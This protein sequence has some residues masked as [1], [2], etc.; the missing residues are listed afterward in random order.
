M[1]TNPF[2]NDAFNMVSLTQAINIL[3]TLYGRVGQLKIFAD[4]GVRTR[5]IAVEEMNGVLTLLPTAP[6]GSVGAYNKMGKRKVRTFKVPHIPLDD[7]IFP[8]EYDGIRDFGSEDEL[9]T[10]AK[11]M[12]DHLQTAKNKFDITIEHLRMGAL[13]GIILDADGST[14]YNLY[15]EFGITQKEVHFDLET[16]ETDVLAKCR[17]VCRHIE[18]NLKGEIFTGVYCL[19]SSLF[20]DALVSHNN[21]SKY[22]INWQNAN[23]LAANGQAADP[24]RGFVFGGI[25]FEEYRGNAPDKDGNIRKFIEDGEAHF[26]PM[27]TAETFKT[28]YAPADFIETVNTIG[29]PLYAK[30]VV[31]AMGRKVDLHI[32]SN[33]LPICYRP[34]VLV[35]GTVE[36]EE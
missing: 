2:S 9:K 27:G 26:F 14:L 25:T 36:G 19:C 20:F 29:L 11:V 18:D 28:I 17:E 32:Q 35:K 13:K 16:A 15:D 12:N 10:L 4:K 1:I 33:P 8:S 3:P 22:Y 6:V 30:Q 5:L 21:V 31:E 34:A 7:E 23:I 24:R